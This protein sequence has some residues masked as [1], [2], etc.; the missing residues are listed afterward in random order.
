MPRITPLPR[1]EA[2]PSAAAI[3]DLVFGPDRDPAVSPG[4][5]TG[6]PGS[7]FTTWAHTPDVLQAFQAYR[8]DPPVIA[9]RLR[10]LAVARA[11]YAIRSH[12]VFSQNCK[13]ARAAG[14]SEEKI[15]AIPFWTVSHAFDDEERA[16]LA[17]ADAHA[18]EN[19]RVHDEVFA[20]LRKT[21]SE[22]EVIALAFLIAF[23][24][25]HARA[26]RALHL[27]YDDVPERIV[28]IPAPAA[29]SVQDWADPK[30][31]AAKAAKTPVAP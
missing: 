29:P 4:T 1:A 12:F 8:P 31:A 25:M 13:A 17:F 23:F 16:V 19:G 28:E 2:S 27:E 20:A 14:V 3:Y 11:A 30:W 26:S 15:A 22:E 21:L 5:A 10:S 9:P 6:T 18:L 24:S 7:F